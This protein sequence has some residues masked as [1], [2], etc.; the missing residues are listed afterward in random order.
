MEKELFSQ[1]LL[2]EIRNKFH[3]I[4]TSPYAGKRVFLDSVSGAL[5]LKNMGEKALAEIISY[6]QNKRVD[7]AS[8]H[9]AC[10]KRKFINDA[11]LFLGAR[12]GHI[13]PAMSGTHAVYRCVNAVCN[14]SNP[15]DNIVTSRLEHPAAFES[16]YQFAKKYKLERRVADFD[17]NNGIVP[18]KNV[19]EL[20]D[21]NTC[22]LMLIHGSNITGGVNKVKNITEKARKINPDIYV[23]VDGVQYAPHRLINVQ[24][25]NVD[26][27]LISGYKLFC[28]KGSGI[29]YINDR[30][31]NLPHWELR[32]RPEGEWAIGA[33]DES[34]YAGFSAVIDYLL[35]LGG[36]STDSKDKRIRVEAAMKSISSHTKALMQLVLEGNKRR[37]GL[38][39]MDNIDILGIGDNLENRTGLISFRIKGKDSSKI[40]E[41]YFKEAQISLSTR[42]K[43]I[44][45]RHVLELLDVD[46]LIRVSLCHYN[47]PSEID[48][49][50]EATEKFQLD[51]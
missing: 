36:K 22:L 33:E 4:E 13:I 44:Y 32:E 16:T 20:I 26:A 39:Y 46:N 30:F 27:Y 3:Y 17:K 5:R 18:E 23:V 11:K 19:I 49:F 21:K 6:A 7:P 31:D 43:N 9:F 2:E 15:G 47:S 41:R 28:K 12:S 25:L 42:E 34:T 35:W 14:S 24:D 40:A 48:K 50:L 1:D 51:K 8:E 29:G 38:K 45:G 37:K 10:I